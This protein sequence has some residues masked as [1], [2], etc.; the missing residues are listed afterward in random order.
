MKTI[1]DPVYSESEV[2]YVTYIV[3]WVVLLGLLTLSWRAAFSHL[4]VFSLII[5]LGIA[6]VKAALVIWYFMHLR[7]SPKLALCLFAMALVMVFIGAV[8]TLSDFLTRGGV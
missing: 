2:S 4:G 1:N 8:L 7:S 5:A 6:A 3:T